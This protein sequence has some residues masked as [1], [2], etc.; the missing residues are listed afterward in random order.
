MGTG[1]DGTLVTQRLHFT[2]MPWD[3][4]H[5]LGW[6]RIIQ[7][8]KDSGVKAI[9]VF[10]G[11]ERN[12]AKADEVY[13]HYL[14]YITA[15]NCYPDPQTARRRDA[16]KLAQARGLIELERL[17]RLQK[18]TKLTE[19]FRALPVSSREQVTLALK[20]TI[21][22]TKRFGFALPFSK[23]EYNPW[24]LEAVQTIESTVPV[25]DAFL[26]AYAADADNVSQ[27]TATEN[28]PL[29][30]D[31]QHALLSRVARDVTSSA[32]VV[33]WIED[34]ARDQSDNG[35]TQM[36]D[37]LHISPQVSDTMVPLLSTSIAMGALPLAFASLF[38]EYCQSIST[39]T[40]LSQDKHVSFQEI[41][42]D[43]SEY[44]MSKHQLQFT[45]DE[46]KLWEELAESRQPI[47]EDG[48]EVQNL[49]VATEAKLDSLAEKSG[50]MSQSYERRNN[51]PTSKT[52]EESKEIIKAMGIPCL[53]SSGPFEAEALAS[54]L[55]LNGLADY[56]AS[57]DTVRRLPKLI[58][59]CINISSGC[60]DI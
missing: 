58:F 12:K 40:S 36:L 5:V 24:L 7:E 33:P 31:L 55:V 29:E 57:E 46:G 23:E 14:L 16:R 18:L 53:E 60:V 48:L 25:D 37:N 1:S 2:S 15:S 47:S 41:S 42:E 9:C 17:K 52:Y 44:A 19:E 50:L 26:A 4:R 6:H 49:S 59:S 35:V 21:S 56:V 20:E 43:P 54:S 22:K 39:L 34:C 10:D 27:S 30:T 32:D 45:I 38:L 8:L 3:Q 11:L 51:P 13:Q 28:P